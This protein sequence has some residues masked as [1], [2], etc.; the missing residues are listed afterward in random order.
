[1][2]SYITNTPDQQRE[3]LE[4]CG[5]DSLDD[6]FECIPADLRPKSFNLP[7]GKSELEVQ[8]YF[9]RVASHNYSQLTTFIGGGIYDHFIPAAVSAI[10]GRS[11]FYTAYTP[12]QAEASQGKV[13]AK[14]INN[15]ASAGIHVRFRPCILRLL[16]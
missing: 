1:M 2:S 12:Y 14:P 11:E 4:V 15:S 6:L 3:M 16:V 7:S 10:A 13:S 9:E 8:R 5:V